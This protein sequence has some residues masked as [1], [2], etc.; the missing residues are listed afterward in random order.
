MHARQ[1]RLLTTR[2]VQVFHNGQRRGL[3]LSNIGTTGA[4]LVGMRPLPPGTAVT[5][6]CRH[7]TIPAEVVWQRDNLTGV[8]FL[9]SLRP[10]EFLVFQLG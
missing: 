2:L 9:S 1:Q 8:H 4:C 3:E 6:H 7:L 5:I 10:D